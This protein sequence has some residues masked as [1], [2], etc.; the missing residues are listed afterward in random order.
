M[1]KVCISHYRTILYIMLWL[2][3]AFPLWH[4]YNISIMIV[5]A[6][7]SGGVFTCQSKALL[8]PVVAKGTQMYVFYSL[9]QNLASDYNNQC[10][11]V[12]KDV[13]IKCKRRELRDL[14][15]PILE[16]SAAFIRLLDDL[17]NYSIKSW[18]FIF[19]F[20]PH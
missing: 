3:E 15:A 18:F 17:K 11:Q 2:Y 9:H 12:W 13:K 19:F 5:S 8:Q 1:P 7:N 4:L 20:V 6:A 16:K 14:K 10:F